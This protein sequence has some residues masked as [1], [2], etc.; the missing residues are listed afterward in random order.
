MPRLARCP[1]AIDIMA[2]FSISRN[3]MTMIYLSPD[4]Y[5]DAFE[6]SLDLHKFD[7]ATHATACLS[8]LETGGH[9]HLATMSPGELV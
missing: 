2:D 3:D 1:R 5:Y 7:I 6:Q 8:H 4:P 9:L